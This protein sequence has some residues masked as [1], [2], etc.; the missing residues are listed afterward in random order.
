LIWLPRNFS[1]KSVWALGFLVSASITLL[2]I[3]LAAPTLKYLQEASGD[4]VWRAKAAAQSTESERR[5]ILVDIDEKSL[6]ELGPW[7]W[8]RERI[9][10]LVKVLGEQGASLQMFDIVFAEPRPGDAELAKAIALHKPIFSEILALETPLSNSVG[11]LQGA[12]SWP[13]CVKPFQSAS[14]YL[15][16][17]AS[18]PVQAGHITPRLEVDGVLRHQPAI[19]CFGDKAYPSLSLRSLMAMSGE[20]TLRLERGSLMQSDWVLTSSKLLA[21]PIPLNAQ[22]DTRFPWIYANQRFISVSAADVLSA[23]HPKNIFTNTLVL[24][25]SSAFGLN[26]R[27]TTPLAPLAA[28]MQAHAEMMLGF[29]D[30]AIPFTPR[31]DLYYQI[32]LVILG[33][34]ILVSLGKS[35]RANYL[36]PLAGI[37]SAIVCWLTFAY[38]LWQHQWWLSWIYPALFLVITSLIL[39]LL[40]H[41]RSRI[42]RDRLFEHLSSYLP[43]AVAAS[44]TMQSPSDAIRA[45]N[46][47]A[48]VMFADIRNFSSYCENRPPE[49]SAAVLHAF[50]SSMT[51]IVEK[52]GGVIESF[53]GDAVIAVWAD[54]GA[55]ANPA[56]LQQTIVA[57]NELIDAAKTFLPNPAP[58]DL[59]PLALGIGIEL[60]SVLAGSFGLAKRR[61]HLVLGP[62]VT[63]ASCL[64]DM[65]AE[66]SHPILIGESLAHAL[67]GVALQPM[68]VFLL[69]GLKQS[70]QIYAYPLTRDNFDFV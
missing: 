45:K 40:E 13:N 10:K 3:G 52:H 15:A 42:D 35:P 66:L 54:E 11:Q 29:L 51:R 69:E 14:A 64:V 18:L 43:S 65:T 32:V 30:N 17:S 48:V 63:V 4:W 5:L 67:K 25:G 12:L 57:A 56:Y 28:G 26:D 60:G 19:I 33:L 44:L 20:E 59:E 53:E 47:L 27:I 61:T 23:R 9:A 38:F 34:V 7:P 70:H 62:T 1:R 46:Q 68:G 36:I 21:N 49:E 39:G 50:F 6:Q 41:A 2:L 58:A 31:I 16:N 55:I 8:P 24:V 22:G 37:V